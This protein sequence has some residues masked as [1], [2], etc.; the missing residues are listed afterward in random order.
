MRLTQT[1]NTITALRKQKYHAAVMYLGLK[2]LFLFTKHTSL[3]QCRNN[4][5]TIM[6]VLLIRLR[7]AADTLGIDA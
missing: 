6:L 5:H 1:G 2:K 7:I 4:H 3:G